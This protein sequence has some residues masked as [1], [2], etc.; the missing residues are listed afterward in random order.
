MEIKNLLDNGI[1]YSRDKQVQ[2]VVKDGKLRISNYA[3]ELSEQL[4]EYFKPFHASRNGLGLGLYIVKSIL[5]I[6]K[7]KLQY[8]HEDGKNIFT[9][10]Q[11]IVTK[12]MIDT[13]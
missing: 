6:H 5:D 3:E 13:A 12:S 10:Y 9:I 7:L 1:K 8:H 4:E 2:I 11:S